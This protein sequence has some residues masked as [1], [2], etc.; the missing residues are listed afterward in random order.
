MLT[1][2]RWRGKRELGGTLPYCRPGAREPQHVP[3]AQD[4]ERLRQG[5]VQNLTLK[6]V[7]SESVQLNQLVVTLFA[8]NV[9]A[10]FSSSAVS[11][12]CFVLFIVNHFHK[13]GKFIFFAPTF[14]SLCSSLRLFFMARYP[15]A[16]CH[17]DAL[18]GSSPAAPA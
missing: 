12:L 3:A 13:N 16:T 5:A 7:E 11:V 6:D 10:F 14:I 17:F 2:K 18:V 8:L 15:W 9:F 1:S 4:Q